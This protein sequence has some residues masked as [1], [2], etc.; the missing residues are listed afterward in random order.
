[1]KKFLLLTALLFSV[2]SAGDITA[3]S[4]TESYKFGYGIRIDNKIGSQP[5]FGVL[6]DNKVELKAIVNTLV[7]GANEGSLKMFVGLDSWELGFGSTFG[8]A[9]F[10]LNWLPSIRSK[11]IHPFLGINATPAQAWLVNAGVYISIQ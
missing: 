4:G 9:D 10:E 3:G 6:V 11:L 2:A 1:M 8:Q 5:Y 7:N